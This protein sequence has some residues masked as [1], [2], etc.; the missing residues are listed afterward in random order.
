MSSYVK[1]TECSTF[2]G[3]GPNEIAPIY[4]RSGSD[5]KLFSE[6]DIIF[7]SITAIKIATAKRGERA[8]FR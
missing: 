3:A 5:W 6:I 4:N 7:I 2:L 8:F 1:Q